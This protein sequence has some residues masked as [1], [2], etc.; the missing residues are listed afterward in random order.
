MG[1]KYRDILLQFVSEATLLSLGGGAIGVL[2]GLA[3]SLSLNGR[4]LLGQPTQTAFDTEVALMALA[5]SAAIGLFFGIYPA[6][7]AA[8]LHPIEALRSE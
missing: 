4:S 5:V 2:L 7:R 1:A 3:L 8:R 6:M